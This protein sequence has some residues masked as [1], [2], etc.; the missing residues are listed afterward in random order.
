MR[1]DALSKLASTSYDYLKKKV[2]VE[3]LPERSIDNQKVNTISTIPECTKPYVDYLRHGV[4]PDDPEEVRKV[5]KESQDQGV[6]FH[7]QRQPTIPERVFKPMAKM[8]L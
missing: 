5:S 2:L 1:A 7:N 6:I 3:V 8:H 4:L